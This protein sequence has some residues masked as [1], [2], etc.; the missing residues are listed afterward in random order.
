MARISVMR[1]LAYII[2]AT[3]GFIIVNS[4]APQVLALVPG[5]WIITLIVGIVLVVASIYVGRR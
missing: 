2:G 5:G 3:G 1:L 4:L